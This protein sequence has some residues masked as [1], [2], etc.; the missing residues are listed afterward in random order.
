MSTQVTIRSSSLW[1]MQCGTALMLAKSLIKARSVVDRC[2]REL[3]HDGVNAVGNPAFAHMKCNAKNFGAQRIDD[4]VRKVLKRMRE[5]QLGLNQPITIADQRPEE[6]T[7][8]W[9][10]NNWQQG[11]ADY[12]FTPVV[13]RVLPRKARPRPF[14]NSSSRGRSTDFW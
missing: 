8:F 11:V 6:F 4:L 2:V 14:A 5:I 12:V 7:S 13:A 10:K 3:E 1:P 9:L